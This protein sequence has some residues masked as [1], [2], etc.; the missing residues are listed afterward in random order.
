MT[1]IC[2]VKGMLGTKIVPSNGLLPDPNHFAYF[3]QTFV[4][5]KV[6]F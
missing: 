1:N 2:E 3:S 4:I 5:L 6:W